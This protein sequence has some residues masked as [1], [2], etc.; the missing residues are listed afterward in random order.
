[1]KVLVKNSEK[2]KKEVV[3]TGKGNG[4]LGCKSVLEIEAEDLYKTQNC[5]YRGDCDVY[6][7]ITCPECGVET[8]VEGIPYKI[9]QK[10]EFKP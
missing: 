4:G 5:D 7:T 6:S 2:W 8:D 9:Q 1:M 10:L 3:C